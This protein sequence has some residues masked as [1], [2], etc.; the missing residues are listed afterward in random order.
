MTYCMSDYSPALSSN[1]SSNVD[2]QMKRRTI[3]F[4]GL[5]YPSR[6]DTQQDAPIQ[7]LPED[8]GAADAVFERQESAAGGTY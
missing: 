3:R 4:Y 2:V 7:E 6:S 8:V 1:R 5:T